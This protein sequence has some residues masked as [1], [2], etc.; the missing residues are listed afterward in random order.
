M[1][2]QEND[3]KA[4]AAAVADGRPS[5]RIKVKPSREEADRQV[6]ELMDKHHGKV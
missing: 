3:S 5:P 6:R 2:L 4:D 1:N